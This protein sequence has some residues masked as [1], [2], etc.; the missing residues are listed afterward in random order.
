[1][2]ALFAIVIHQACRMAMRGNIHGP[3]LCVRDRSSWL[4]GER[5]RGDRVSKIFHMQ[6][7]HFAPV[8]TIVL[9]KNNKR[10]RTK[11]KGCNSTRG[12]IQ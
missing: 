3:L 6:F 12:K 11:I 7:T 4:T 2:N 5:E 10:A 9:R 8:Q 1:M